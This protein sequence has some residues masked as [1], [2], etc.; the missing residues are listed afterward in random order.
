MTTKKAIYNQVVK[1]EFHLNKKDPSIEGYYGSSIGNEYNVYVQIG[2]K[3]KFKGILYMTE[4]KIFCIDDTPCNV[5]LEIYT[6][7][8]NLDAT[9]CFDADDMKSLS[10]NTLAILLDV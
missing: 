5:A 6:S 9:V 10:E 4:K 8:G 1:V 7:D 3:K 2:Q